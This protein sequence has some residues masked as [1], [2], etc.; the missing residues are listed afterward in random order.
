MKIAKLELKLKR[1]EEQNA[2]LLKRNDKMQ[3]LYRSYQRKNS[4]LDKKLRTFKAKPPKK[5]E[6]DALIEQKLGRYFTPAQIR[7][8]QGENWSRMSKITNEDYTRAMAL[9]LVSVRAYKF[10]R[11]NHYL[12]LPGP[13]TLAKASKHYKVPTGIHASVLKL[14]KEPGPDPDPDDQELDVEMKG[15]QTFHQEQI[16]TVQQVEIQHHAVQLQPVELHQTTAV[17]MQE[18]QLHHGTIPTFVKTE[19]S[20]EVYI[21]SEDGTTYIQQIPIQQE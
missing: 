11:K 18:I 17:P 2:L 13:T 8:L 4:A 15:V 3:V 7:V 19:G 14:L 1:L 10:L 6:V 9:R 16:P 5:E 21:Q 12:P 20:T